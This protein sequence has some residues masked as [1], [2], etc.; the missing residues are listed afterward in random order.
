LF[1]SR[2]LVGGM[3]RRDLREANSPGSS[4]DSIDV[5]VVGCGEI[6]WNLHLPVLVN[7]PRARV[8]WVTDRDSTRASR[9]ARSFGV[10]QVL[11]PTS[12]E[13]LPHADAVLLAIPYGVRE[14]YYAGLGARGTAV[15]AE[16]PFARRGAEHDDICSRFGSE[17]LA[18][19]LQR[20]SSGFARVLSELVASRIFGPLRRMNFEL[21][22]P[23]VRTAGRYS[24]D[25]GLAGGGI[26]FEVGVHFLDLLL[27]VSG[28]VRTEPKA[29][30][31]ERHRGF[32]VETSAVLET[33]DRSGN[34]VDL[35]LLCTNLRSASMEL[36]LEF[37]TATA[38]VSVFGH[39]GVE[40]RS[41]RSRS[42]FRIGP[43]EGTYPETAAQMAFAHWTAFFN[44]LETRTPNLSSARGTR[45]TTVALEQL[46]GSTNN[47]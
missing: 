40:V 14:P 6:S 9:T 37:E 43:T 23:G 10:Q 3:A 13:D 41:Q 2:Q 19:G 21:G 44:G 45:V 15:Y 39:G 7:H 25:L 36:E 33:I 47:E 29:I 27:F 24:S 46:Y 35:S 16:K 42:R 30:R 11:L 5:G 12:P 32:D 4:R 17:R 18:V 34:A 20:R 31:M 8:A 1:D 38:R 28:A 26:L 22:E